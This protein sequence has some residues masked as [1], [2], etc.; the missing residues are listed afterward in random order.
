M[1]RPRYI[2]GAGNE[3]V[4]DDTNRHHLFWQ[5]D[6]YRTPV[7]RKFREQHGAVLLL[8]KEVHSELHN[9]VPAPKKPHPELMRAIYTHLRN[10]EFTHTYDKFFE[11]VDYTGK[12]AN[13]A[14]RPQL[15]EDAYWLHDNLTQQQPFVELGR[16]ALLERRDGARTE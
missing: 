11:L 14:V 13:R 1:E 2:D 9:E 15:A 12:I 6:W 16:V 4:R 7:E 8:N 5:R 3:L 10:T